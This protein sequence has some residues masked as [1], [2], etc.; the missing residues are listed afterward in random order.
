MRVKGFD[1]KH[2]RDPKFWLFMVGLI[3]FVFLLDKLF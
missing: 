2:Y 3:L 1:T